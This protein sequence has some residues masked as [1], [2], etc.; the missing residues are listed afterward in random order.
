MLKQR[1]K[2]YGTLL[3]MALRPPLLTCGLAVLLGLCVRPI[4][5]R[6]QEPQ[7]QPAPAETPPRSDVETSEITEPSAPS[8]APQKL[9]LDTAI[10]RALQRA[11]PIELARA[12]VLRAE[13]LLRQA[14]AGWLP[15]L[16]LN[17][18]YTRLDAERRSNGVR[19]AARDQL[20]G[21]LRVT[22]PLVA[23]SR[24]VETGLAADDVAI[25][26]AD[27]LED[28][29]QVA[30]TVAGAYLAVMAQHRVIDVNERA[31]RN[32]KAHYEYAHK[33]FVGGIGNELDDVRAAQEYESSVA[34]LEGS[35]ADLVAS[36]EALGVL[37]GDDRP[38]D[39]VDTVQLK[40]T[41]DLQRALAEAATDRADVQAGRLRTRSAEDA[42]DASWADYMPFLSAEFRPFVSEPPTTTLPR[43]GWQAQLVL[44][45]PLYDGGARYGAHDQ[46]KA[47]LAQSRTLLDAALRQAKSEVRVAFEAARRA[48]AGLSA[49]TR[50]AALA[51][52]ALQM[53][54]QA[55]QAGATTDIE[56]LDAERRARDAETAAV[57]AE[58]AARRARV[59]LLA[60]S[61]RWP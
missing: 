1:T 3:Y 4:G 13:G 23:A 52:R 61:G 8:P 29:R 17:G 9:D 11:V 47:E 51:G 15:K 59:D 41:P 49:A 10:R 24:W 39:V 36:Q 18:S 5:S 57:I 21:D 22:V 50:A 55:Y 46:R 34:Q 2:S 26:R 56:V 35:R 27:A 53:A 12:E 16:T 33:R 42:L 54:M 7:P 20:A 60:A 25:A 45:V 38:L 19:L 31:L 40:A 28:R 6:A 37:L 14:R 32:A 44:S 43:T 58:D 48:D 30:L